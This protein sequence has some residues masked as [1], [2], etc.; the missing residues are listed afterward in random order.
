MEEKVETI[1]RSIEEQ[2]S[3]GNDKVSFQPKETV[4]T[5]E[6]LSAV[7]QHPDFEPKA[8][9]IKS[10]VLR[11]HQLDALPSSLGNI[12]NLKKLD[13]R[14]NQGLKAVEPG[15]FLN[16]LDVFD[17]GEVGM[18]SSSLSGFL[19]AFKPGV[20]RL[21][22]DIN[23]LNELPAVLSKFV[24]LNRMNLNANSLT[25]FPPVVLEMPSLRELLM[26]SNR[27]EHLPDDFKL[28]TGLTA[29]E[30]KQNSLRSLPASLAQMKSLARFLYDENPLDSCAFR[31]TP[32][33]WEEFKGFLQQICVQ[34]GQ[35]FSFDAVAQ[36][37]VA[38]QQ[39]GTYAQALPI[40]TSNPDRL[41]NITDVRL[42][43]LALEDLPPQ[44]FQL[45]KLQFL[46]LARN[47]LRQIP[48]SIEELA[49]LETLDISFNPIN[50][51]PASMGVLTRLKTLRTRGTPWFL[52][53]PQEILDS[54]VDKVLVY[55][56]EI[57]QDKVSNKKILLV[58]MGAGE[59][60]KTSM[61]NALI[62]EA[63]G[64]SKHIDAETGRTIGIDIKAWL[65]TEGDGLEFSAMDVGGQVGAPPPFMAAV[66]S[67]I[68][69]VLPFMSA[70]PPFMHAVL[71][72]MGPTLCRAGATL[73]CALYT[74]ALSS[75]GQPTRV[76]DNLDRLRP[77][78]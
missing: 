51:L 7:L 64:T 4:L 77:V 28:L 15:C 33:P 25:M 1:L 38:S 52:N 10:M 47:R 60:G 76:L 65:P 71:R 29:L 58:A 14:Q 9:L 18:S 22:L 26:N 73:H 75:S 16:H 78:H 34:S 49:M 59:A 8:G 68:P 42:V 53:P 20:T 67:F 50:I 23:Q 5:T 36:E 21:E 41:Q 61:V 70:V 17:A 63:S 54:G 13:V 40:I 66:L 69:S 19:S 46:S 6:M 55:L 30:L 48:H 11:G 27:I 56:R 2:L 32:S 31:N 39:D 24:A 74:H 3:D 72:F 37:F 45:K 43:G 62:N 12:P 35:T 57:L 44:L